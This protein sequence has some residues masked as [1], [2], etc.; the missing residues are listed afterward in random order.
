MK[1]SNFKY[2]AKM[3]IDEM[4]KQQ[5]WELVERQK[6]I[7]VLDRRHEFRKVFG[8]NRVGKIVETAFYVTPLQLSE[9]A[10]KL[11]RDIGRDPVSI[12]STSGASNA[13]Y[14]G[15]EMTGVPDERLNALVT[16]L[17]DAIDALLE[18]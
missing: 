16:R 4:L 3:N 13:I 14:W 6:W 12:K 15:I 5:G 8:T 1:L 7:A 17:A 2:R 9:T 11:V 10:Q 18:Q